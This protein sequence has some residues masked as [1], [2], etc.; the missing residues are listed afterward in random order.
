GTYLMLL[1]LFSAGMVFM[2]KE[3][4]R[5]YIPSFTGLYLLSA[6]AYFFSGQIL[7]KQYLEYAFCA[8]GIGLV[9][10][11]TFGTPSWLRPALHSEYYVKTGLVI[12][13]AE[14]L[15]SNITKFGFY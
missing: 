1:V 8:L 13:G 6:L 10:A 12:M 2:G 11:N 5:D 14:V 7:M 3:K 4:L 15:F 9:I